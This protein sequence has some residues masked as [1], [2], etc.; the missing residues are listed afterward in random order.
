MATH[1]RIGLQPLVI[2]M[3]TQT[4]RV[5]DLP[6]PVASLLMRLRWPTSQDALGVAAWAGTLTDQS[7]ATRANAWVKWD[8]KNLEAELT[9][10]ATEGP[11]SILNLRWTVSECGAATFL[12]AKDRAGPMAVDQAVEAFSRGVV[13][14][15]Q[16]SFVLHPLQPRRKPGF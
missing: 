7:G 12:G 15:G 13:A 3:T 2:A 1:D 5:A 9:R 10:G 16:P 6:V 4:T 11:L 8:G 14:L